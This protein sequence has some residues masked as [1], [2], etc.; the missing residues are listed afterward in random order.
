M[1]TEIDIFIAISPSHFG[2]IK[3]SDLMGSRQV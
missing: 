1:K 2:W 3:N